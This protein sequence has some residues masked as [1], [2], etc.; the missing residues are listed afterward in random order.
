M[1]HRLEETNV[2]VTWTETYEQRIGVGYHDC[3]ICGQETPRPTMDQMIEFCKDH[4]DHC[5]MWPG[6]PEDGWIPPGWTT[7][8]GEGLICP[9]CTKTKLDA[10]GK[11]RKAK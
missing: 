7:E 5:W 4:P 8:S 1:A 3:P 10:L 11:R 6:D 9:E 2:T